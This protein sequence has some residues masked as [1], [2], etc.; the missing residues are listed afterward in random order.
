MTKN[1]M[2]NIN[3]ERRSIIGGVLWHLLSQIWLIGRIHHARLIYIVLD[4]S[5]GNSRPVP[6]VH[7]LHV[8]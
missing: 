3:F 7:N 1:E 2:R 4:D 8:V 6:A 5:D